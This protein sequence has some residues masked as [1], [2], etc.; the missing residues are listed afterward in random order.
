MLNTPS[1]KKGYHK[2]GKSFVL[3]F[4]RVS[5]YGPAH[6]FSA[7]VVEEFYQSI[8]EL[9]KTTSPVVLI[10][11]RDQFFLEDEPLDRNL[12]Y[13]KMSLHFK[14]AKVTSISIEKDLQKREVEDFVK[15]FLD[16]RRYPSAEHMRSASAAL[17]VNH[18]KINHIFY[19]K[20]TEDDQVV[21]KS[22]AENSERLS[23]EL[24][25]SRHYQEALGMIAG[26]AAHGGA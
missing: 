14:K 7:Q 10:H 8:L 13:A 15:V 26:K 11:A 3:M 6:P 22:V 20:V 25:S 18:I 12:N 17:R 2:A 21:A 1:I 9:L 5:M 19:Q 24:D 23:S 16:T 4:N